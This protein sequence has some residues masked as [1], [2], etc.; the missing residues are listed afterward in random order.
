MVHMLPFAVVWYARQPKKNG[1]RTAMGDIKKL[2]LLLE[3]DNEPDRNMYNGII[4]FSRQHD[5]RDES[6]ALKAFISFLNFM[7]TDVERLS[8]KVKDDFH[9]ASLH[10][11]MRPD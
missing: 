7:G 5:I 3:M 9:S 2:T 11:G 6:E 8:Q 10:N 4:R 1:T